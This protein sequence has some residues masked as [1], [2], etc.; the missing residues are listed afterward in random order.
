MSNAARSKKVAFTLPLLLLFLGAAALAQPA[1][2]V[3][4]INTTRSGGID[5]ETV[6][7]YPSDNSVIL[8][9]TFFFVADDGI[10]GS[11]LWRTDGTD[12]GTR[13]VAD[14]CP[15]S[16]A[17]SPRKLTVVGGLIF[18][19]ADDGIH[20]RELWKSDGTPAGTVLIA[21]LTPEDHYGGTDPLAELNGL[22]LFAGPTSWYPHELWRSDGT[23]A[24][25]FRLATIGTGEGNPTFYLS[26]TRFGGKLF[27][28]AE[29][30]D[31][32]WELWTTDGTVAGTGLLKDISPGPL[33]SNPGGIVVAG[34]RVLFSAEGPEGRELWASDGTAAGTV[35]VRDIRPGPQGSDLRGLAVL[36]GTVFFLASPDGQSQQL[37]KSDGTPGGTL[38]VK[39][40]VNSRSLI[41]AGGR[42]VFFAAEE[43]GSQQQIW[44]S[45]GTPGGTL[46]IGTAPSSI[47]SASVAGGRLY[48]F[49]GCEL[50]TSD[51]TAPGTGPLA[52]IGGPFCESRAP[53][54]LAGDG[55]RIL[56]FADDG[57]HGSEPWTSDGTP[58]GTSL[59]ADLQPG[60]GSSALDLDPLSAFAGG[61]WYFRAKGGENTGTQLW[62][63]DGTAAG[64]RTLLSNP[65][66]PGFRLNLLGQLAGPRAFFDLDGTLLFQGDDGATGAELWRSDG[67]PAGT[68]LVKDLKPGAPSSLPGEFTRAGS[69]VF[70][71]SDAGTSLE[72]L[73]KTDGTTAGTQLLR[74]AEQF[75]NFGFYSPRDLTAF[76]TGL[77]FLGSCCVDSAPELMK[78]DGTPSGTQPVGTWSFFGFSIVSL[79]NQV[80]FQSGNDLNEL[81]R[82]DGT[83][84]GT[85][86]LGAVLSS[87]RL[88]ADASVVRDGVLF[89]VG[90]SPGT[91]EELWRS[92]GSSAGT[93]LL[94]ETVSGP[95]SRHLGPFAVAGPAL[96]FAVGSN[97]I[98]KN[99]AGGTSLVSTLPGDPTVGI[100]SLTPLGG[101]VYFTYDD[102]VHGRELWT[103]DGTEAGT[104]IVEDIQP[105]PGSSDPRQLHAEGIRLLF[106]ASDGVHGTEPWR[107]DGTALGTRMLQDIDPGDLPSSPAEFTASGPNVYFIANDGTTGVELWALPRTALLATFADTPANHWAWSFIEALAA[108][109]ITAGC[110]PDTYCPDGPVTRAQAAVFLVRASH[111]PAYLPPPATGTLFQDIPAGHWAGRWIEQLVA[112]GVAAGC[113]GGNYCPDAPLN[114]AEIARLLLQTRHGSGFAPPPPTGKVFNDV[115]ADDVAAPW[116]ERLAA[117]GVTLG[118]GGGAYCP[119]RILTRAEM[120]V[121]L[122]RLFGLLFP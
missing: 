115:P 65:R 58:A 69:T 107:S 72:K 96:F 121:F 59:M 21:D 15:G 13:L 71:R 103:S 34:G 86:S 87:R 25:T 5:P 50:W 22:L 52:T 113:G 117:E 6:Q 43:F 60:A 44:T 83:A 88:L 26:P 11:E 18:F 104:R 31:H 20:G 40:V 47:G 68:F 111:G 118:C 36:G 99:D 97:E 63:T 106:A 114:R 76:G 73:W 10:R 75:H 120:A 91:G 93:Y 55:S 67:T 89:F 35:L 9:S 23:A 4:D 62:T 2:Q 38:P 112:D 108:S 1:F 17:S 102:G 70:F 81:W 85:V 80:L 19:M 46:R 79:G 28:F 109:G 48:F 45:D 64:T 56:F 39:P 42:L 33:G 66:K 7:L 54:F 94:A 95:D 119:S 24:G 14:I 53:L 100:R 3:K 49:T 77:L 51:G 30:S 92:D 8:G 82:S 27:F 110:A 32:G 29:D 57:I 37:W 84:P 12:A 98:W 78:S 122:V 105:G 101:K 90:S 16:C 41:V 61:H 74:A 116:I